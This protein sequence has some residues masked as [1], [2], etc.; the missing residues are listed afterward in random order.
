M[1][2]SIHAQ[3][4]ILRRINTRRHTI[5]VVI[6]DM[7]QNILVNLHHKGDFG[8]NA[9]RDK[10]GND[11]NFNPIQS[12]DVSVKAELDHDGRRNFHSINI[13]EP[14]VA[15]SAQANPVRRTDIGNYEEWRTEPVCFGS[16]LL[17]SLGLQFQLKHPGTGVESRRME[18][19]DVL[20]QNVE[21]KFKINLNL[22]RVLRV[23]KMD[24]NR[25]YCS[26]AAGNEFFTDPEG[27]I[28]AS[29]G[30]DSIRQIFES[31]FSGLELDGRW[32]PIDTWSGE[33][34]IGDKAGCGK[35]TG[36]GSKGEDFNDEGFFLNPGYGLNPKLN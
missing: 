4:S 18:K 24:F 19:V 10:I 27:N 14:S 15:A 1:Y 30:P 25:S 23:H 31:T 5:N 12:P 17:K 20:G 8:Y 34:G 26:G 2:F 35:G 16:S 13:I 29:T 11:A 32:E 28:Q 33:Y 9:V 21:K 6:A 22:E 7:N 3:T 36:K